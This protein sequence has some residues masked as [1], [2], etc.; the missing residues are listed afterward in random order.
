MTAARFP[1]NPMEA[2]L[3]LAVPLA[4]DPMACARFFVANPEK[5]LHLG[6][7]AFEEYCATSWQALRE[8]RR[9]RPAPRPLPP[10]P[11]DAA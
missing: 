10:T 1:R 9:K 5:F 7:E 2:P 3:P 6:P 8:A 4:D 11:G